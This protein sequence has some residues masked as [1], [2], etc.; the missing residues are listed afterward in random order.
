LNALDRCPAL[1][2]LDNNDDQSYAP[3]QSIQHAPTHLL[4][5]LHDADDIA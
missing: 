3:V 2:L 5:L 1:I 4:D